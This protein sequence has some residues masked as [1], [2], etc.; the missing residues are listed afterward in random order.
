PCIDITSRFGRRCP[1]ASAFAVPPSSLDFLQGTFEKIYLLS[2]LPQQTLQLTD[3]FCER[4]LP[5]IWRGNAVILQW[6]Q[7]LSPF[8]SVH[9]DKHPVL[10]I[11]RPPYRICEADPPPSDRMPADTFP[12][13]SFPSATPFAAKSAPGKCRRIGVQ[14][15]L[16]WPSSAVCFG[17]TG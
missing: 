17:P 13:V 2:V 8:G 1:R 15:I 7:L 14:S 11:E 6:F 16:N 10:L 4:E 9:V 3:L 12:P 5:G